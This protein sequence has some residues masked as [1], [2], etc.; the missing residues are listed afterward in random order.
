MLDTSR[1]DLHWLLLGKDLATKMGF[2]ALSAV[3]GATVMRSLPAM[4]SD[5]I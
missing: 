3:C 5:T 4:S 1:A 2:A